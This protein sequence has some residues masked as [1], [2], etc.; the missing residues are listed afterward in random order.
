MNSFKDISYV[1]EGGIARITFNRPEV[2]NSFRSLTLDEIH[3][4]FTDAGQ[5][6]GV[7]VIVLSG[8]GGKAFCSGGDV[9]EMCALTPSTGRIFLNKLWNIFQLMR[10]AGK[11]VLAAVD[12]YCLGGGNEFNMMCDLTIATEKS[13]F[14]QVGPRVGSSPILGATQLLPRCVGE[15]R[16]R[17]I[18]Y[19]CQR[20]SARQ[21]LEWGWINRVVADASELEKAVSEWCER[22]LSMSP[23]ALRIAK[24]SFNF[25][26]DELLPSYLHG[27]D[28][29]CAAYGSAELVEGMKAFLEKRPA[30]FAQFRK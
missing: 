14:G 22:I 6:N 17:E 20:Y 18:V 29:L 11:P 8:A 1:K 30:N 3:Q 26:S 15:K 5:D 19:L 9:E 28:I 4:A 21:A 13:S 12:G 24:L 16:A 2:L 10:G 25:A 27:I 7:G 23:Q